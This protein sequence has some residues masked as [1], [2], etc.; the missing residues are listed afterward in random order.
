LKTQNP[1][2]EIFQS[3]VFCTLLFNLLLWVTITEDSISLKGFN[4]KC[5]F[6]FVKLQLHSSKKDHRAP[7][8]AP[9]FDAKG[10]FGHLTLIL[11]NFLF[12]SA[13]LL[14]YILLCLSCN[15][16]VE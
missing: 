12:T 9:K 3:G 8:R 11:E 4:M 2:D 5:M 14:G 6:R 16:K 1:N 7:T 10:P 13:S 15:F